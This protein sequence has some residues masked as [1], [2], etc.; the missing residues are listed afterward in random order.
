LE[1]VPGNKNQA[2]CKYCK[3][4]LK[5]KL[6]VLKM[7]GSG[8]KHKH[9]LPYSNQMAMW[10]LPFKPVVVIPN[11]VKKVELK[12]T[13]MAVCHTSFNALNHISDLVCQEGEGSYLQKIKLHR[14][15]ER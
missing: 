3:A 12:L 8:Q 13:V 1:A 14:T 5:A 9:L 6:D 11:E 7:H 10:K 2:S 4:V 15:K